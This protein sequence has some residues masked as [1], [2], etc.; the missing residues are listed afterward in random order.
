MRLPRISVTGTSMSVVVRPCSVKWLVETSST[1]S[2]VTSFLFHLAIHNAAT[3]FF[4][5]GQMHRT[6]DARAVGCH[7]FVRRVA[8]HRVTSDCRTCWRAVSTEAFA[9]N[10]IVAGFWRAPKAF[11]KRA[12]KLAFSRLVRIT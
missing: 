4:C 3:E 8:V 12:N 10:M 9:F 2:R 7:S 5:A 6:R 11:P 1:S